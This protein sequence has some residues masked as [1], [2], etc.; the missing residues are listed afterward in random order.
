MKPREEEEED[1]SL[2][3]S[4]VTTKYQEAAKIANATLEGACVCVCSCMHVQP[5]RRSPLCCSTAVLAK[6]EPG[7]NPID[8]CREGDKAIEERLSKIFNKK[9]RA[10][11]IMHNRLS[12]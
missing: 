3:N 7:A 10:T 4:D 2:A 9:V 5:S 11:Q 1:T 12:C 8:L 6:V